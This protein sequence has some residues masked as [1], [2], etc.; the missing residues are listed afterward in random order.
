[1]M[2]ADVLNFVRERLPKQPKFSH[3]SPCFIHPKPLNRQ[4]LSDPS[5]IMM[6]GRLGSDVNTFFKES[7]PK[8]LRPITPIPEFWAELTWASR[9]EAVVHLDDL[10]LRRVRMGILLPQGGLEHLERI[11][12]LVQ[13]PLGWSDQTWESEVARYESI[14]RENYYLAS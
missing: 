12:Q 8:Q 4:I 9:N 7:D 13:E 14:W 11:R 6:A 2:A 5:W 3:R 1:V 10:L